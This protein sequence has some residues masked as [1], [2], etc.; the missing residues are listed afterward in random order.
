MK[1][2]LVNINTARIP[3]QQDAAK[4]L[5]ALMRMREVRVAT[6]LDE[7]IRRNRNGSNEVHADVTPSPSPIECEALVE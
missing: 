4:K 5:V 7:L 1:F 2:K 3:P 6:Y